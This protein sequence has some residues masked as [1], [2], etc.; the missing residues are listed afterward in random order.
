VTV[1]ALAERQTA[2]VN[3]GEKNTIQAVTFVTAPS[4]ATSSH[5]ER[6]TAGT[7]GDS[8]TGRDSIKG[9]FIAVLG[10]DGRII[11]ERI[12]WMAG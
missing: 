4:T 8:W 11:L 2:N 3:V 6:P 12:V 10:M 7:F 5:R 1:T 9:T